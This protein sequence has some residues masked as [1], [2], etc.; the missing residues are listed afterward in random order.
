MDDMSAALDRLASM[1]QATLA[2]LRATMA[3]VTT[4]ADVAELR[5]KIIR[6]HD[7]CTD[8]TRLFET[9]G[10]GVPAGKGRL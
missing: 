10:Y 2:E 6:L 1:Q 5:D 9:M 7:A 8:M 4:K 3:I